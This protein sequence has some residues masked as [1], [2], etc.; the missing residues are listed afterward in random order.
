MFMRSIHWCLG[1]L[2]ALVFGAIGHAAEPVNVVTYN[3]GLLAVP[4]VG[5][6]V[7]LVEARAEK[8][9]QVIPDFLVA[10]HT[11]I[12]FF[13]ELW[14]EKHANLMKHKLESLGYEVYRPADRFPGAFGNGLLLALR[15]PFRFASVARFTGYRRQSGIQNFTRHGIIAAHIVTAEQNDFWFFGT[16]T[17][18]I[19]TKNGIPTVSDE[20]QTLYD[21][22]YQY[23]SVIDAYTVK[24]NLPALAMG[25]YNVGEGSGDKI[26]SRL[27]TIPYLKSLDSTLTQAQE[28]TW[29][30]KNPLVVHGL[31]KDE[32]SALIDHIF[33]KDG[34][35]KYWFADK[36]E[37]AFKEVQRLRNV[38][39]CNAKKLKDLYD[40]NTGTYKAPL[41]DHYG[42]A[43]SLIFK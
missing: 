20:V 36:V 39:V 13:Q 8:A 32:R 26:Y 5:D 29:D 28:V 18:A 15:K 9:I 25:D 37:V 10:H 31:F 34:S 35:Q 1:I 40:V 14:N 23:Q 7:P 42:V 43:A 33:T 2:F 16:H 30:A 22:I 27:A 12:A 41:S 38:G 6:Q 17:Q 24:D 19:T 21:Q 11:D 4:I 3:L